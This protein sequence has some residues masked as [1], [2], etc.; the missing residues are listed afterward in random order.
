MSNFL[1]LV[2]EA[3][4]RKPIKIRVDDEADDYTENE[5]G[6]GNEPEN[7]SEE[8]S[9]TEEETDDGGT[10]ET[11]EEDEA[12][13][14]DYTDDEEEFSDE[15][16]SD[17][18]SEGEPT[19]DDDTI[20]ADEEPTDYTGD[21]DGGDSGDE[22]TDYTDDDSTDTDDTG[23]DSSMGDEETSEED[24]GPTTDDRKNKGLLDDLIKLKAIVQNFI[25][26]LSAMNLNNIEKV[27]LIGQINSN[28]TQLSEQIHMYIV[29]RF[30]HET[31]VRNL[32]FYNYSIEAVNININMLKKIGKMND[33]K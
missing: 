3:K 30:Q 5:E 24:E 14:T 31:Y 10:D 23:D 33:N 17:T 6:D 11:S 7:T 18:N 26:K 32:Y 21:E 20:P 12:E 22:P 28:L 8:D 27:R 13:P 29:Y 15:E 2:M 1:D 9:D 4:G 16:D 19:E 25:N